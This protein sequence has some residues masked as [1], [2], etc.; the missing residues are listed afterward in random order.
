MLQYFPLWSLPTGHKLVEDLCLARLGLLLLMF[1]SLAQGN[2]LWTYKQLLSQMSPSTEM[3]PSLIPGTSECLEKSMTE[4]NPVVV[5]PLFLQFP[6][7]RITLYVMAFH[8]LL[9]HELFQSL[10][11]CAVLS[12]G[13]AEYL[14]W[15]KPP[16]FFL[17]WSC[18]LLV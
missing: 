3:T 10:V 6:V 9:P 11:E 1:W 8:W 15:E 2:K 5:F 7:T 16:F 4:D 12:Q 14:L 13:T 18:I 17:F